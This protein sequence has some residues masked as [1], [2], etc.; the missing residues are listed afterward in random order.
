MKPEVG[1]EKNACNASELLRMCFACGT[2]DRRGFEEVLIHV[3][4]G[5]ELTIDTCLSRM[6]GS[7]LLSYPSTLK[8][9]CSPTTS[10]QKQDNFSTSSEFNAQAIQGS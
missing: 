3:D 8:P 2:T 6:S 7:Q 4:L 9:Y 10:D 1:S 5:L